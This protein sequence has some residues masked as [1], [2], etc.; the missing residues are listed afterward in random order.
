MNPNDL[1]QS[2]IN[3]GYLKNP[4]ITAAFQNIDRA[5]FVLS[6]YKSQAYEDYPLSIGFDQTISQPL[7]VA[8]M[9]ELLDP[10][11]GE[12]ILDIGAGSGW[13]SALLAEM[14]GPGGQVVAI[15][16]ISQLCQF[17][18]K[19][20][21]KYD[22]IKNG[23]V[24]FYCQDATVEIP[25]SSY[26]KIIVAA[27]VP[28]RNVP[29]SRPS[30]DGLGTSKDIPE[31]WRK[32]L[33]VG[34]KIVTPID[35]S[36]WLFIKKTATDWEEKEYPGFSF[37]PLLKDEKK[38]VSSK[39]LLVTLL[40]IM[41]FSTMLGAEIY[42]PHT[43]YQKSKKVEIEPG[44]GSRKIA[45][46]LKKEGIIRSKWVFVFYVS[47]KGVA[48][49]LKPGQYEFEQ[50][51]IPAIVQKLVK[52]GTNEITIT[53][54]EGWSIKDIAEYLAKE[55]FVSVADF[56][57]LAGDKNLAKFKKRFDFLED[58]PAKVNLEGYLFPD[59]YRI[60]KG[61]KVE[62]IISR[63]LENFGKKLTP[64][65]RMEIKKQDK[66]IFA[67]VVIASLI[68]KEVVSDQDRVVVSG[69][70][71]KRLKAGIPLQVD[72]TINYITGKNT[73][74]VSRE[75]TK[76]DS[77]YNTYKYR[78]LPKGPIANPGLSAVRAAI[79]P[80]S[81]PYLYYLSGT[82]GQII[83]SGTLEEHNLAKVKYLK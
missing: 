9:L 62:D 69:I 56:E 75:E 28:R 57:Y 13:Q 38:S 61:S 14:V 23:R 79:Y 34:G 29:G 47:L 71:W 18:Q 7:T 24:K 78:G 65:L 66:T 22:F 27:A 15:E 70:L 74:R 58:Q 64:D 36:I 39:K 25:D 48:S 16:R 31:L 42:I 51:A 6:E 53:I 82:D 26:D 52:G 76:I 37:V 40:S 10:Q 3:E 21:D 46:L 67:I 1:I 73:A 77:P 35:G 2:L 49:G 4:E 44:L 45:E 54:P 5:D 59:T 8:F 11:P 20:L 72:A 33:K 41:V 83:F 17:A 63:M 50:E 12:K 55:K 43:F 60:Y 68:E 30:A 32:K 81:S 19:N 80:K